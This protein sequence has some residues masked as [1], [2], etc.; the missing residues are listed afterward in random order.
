MRDNSTVSNE[1]LLLR[2]STAMVGGDYQ[3]RVSNQAGNEAV[4][5]TLNGKGYNYYCMML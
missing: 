2:T 1:P 4:S 3:C 5:V